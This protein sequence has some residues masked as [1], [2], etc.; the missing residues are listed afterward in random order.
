[1]M[2]VQQIVAFKTQIDI[3][4]ELKR[5]GCLGALA[6]QELS[7]TNRKGLQNFYYNF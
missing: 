2:L 6:R 5:I 3:L 7:Y 1:M 4:N